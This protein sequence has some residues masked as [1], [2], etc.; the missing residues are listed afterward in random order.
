MSLNDGITQK[1][2]GRAEL[3]ALVAAFQQSGGTV[4]RSREHRATAECRIRGARHLVPGQRALSSSQLQY[5]R[6]G[7][8]RSKSNGDELAGVFTMTC[9]PTVVDF[10]VVLLLNFNR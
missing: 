8:T 5:R 2:R 10:Q 7:L 3:E 6:W 9:H 4:T 1:Q